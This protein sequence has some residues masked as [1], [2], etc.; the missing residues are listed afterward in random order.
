[1]AVAV[2]IH[3]V[4]AAELSSARGG[5]LLSPL[6]YVPLLFGAPVVVLASLSL[7]VAIVA[8]PISRSGG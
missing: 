4:E 7:V 5:G 1:M 6:A 2:G 8:L 3:S